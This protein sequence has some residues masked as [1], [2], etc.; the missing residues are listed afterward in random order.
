MAAERSRPPSR[1]RPSPTRR[2]TATPCAPTD[3]GDG[4]DPSS[5]GPSAR[6][7]PASAA[8]GGLERRP[9]RADHDR[10]AAARRAPTPSCPSS[11]STR[12][13]GDDGRASPPPCRAGRPRAPRRRRPAARR[14]RLQPRHG[15]HPRPPRRARHPRHRRGRR[16]YRRPRVGVLSTGDELVD[17][18]GPLA[19]RPDPRL[20]PRRRCCLVAAGRRRG[21][22]PRHS[23]P[24]TPRPSPRRSLRGRRRPATPCSRPAACRW[25]TSTSCKEVLDLIGDMRWM[26]VAIKPAKPFAFG[27]VDGVP[28]VRAAR[29][30]GVVDG[31]LR[32]VRPP[33][34]PAPGRPPR[35][36]PRPTLP[37]RPSPS[38]A[39]P[40]QP[41]GKLHF[42]RVVVRSPPTAGSRP[43]RP[44]ARARTSCRPW[45]RPTASP[46]VPDGAGVT[47]GGAGR[48]AAARGSCDHAAR[49]PQPLEDRFGRVHRDLRISV[50][51]RCNLRCT[52]CMP[53]EGM[54]W[55][56]RAELLTLRGDR[57]PR[58]ALRRALRLRLAS[59]SPAASPRCGPTCRCS[60][61]KLAAARRRPGADHQRRHPRRWSPTTSPP[62]A[63]G[64]S[65]SR[66]TRC[67]ASRVD[68][69][70]PAAT[71][72]HACSTASTPPSPPGSR[73]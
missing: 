54:E 11:R 5:C 35:R 44:A 57:A 43:A 67:G 52:Y 17:G 63:S 61:S 20:E 31:E 42:V 15:P 55:L 32:A 6:P 49:G 41:D 71:C 1:C 65:T 70:S 21:R 4:R 28:G 37:R 50:T 3:V 64:G 24:T 38:T 72:S 47:A 46:S 69:R 51:D 36:P 8:G 9:G 10:R 34:H 68:R 23:P 18:V 39:S 58:P 25:A 14:R 7:W 2:W 45:R 16:S 40:R 22:R 30:P 59:A 62:P 73:R 66:S 12:D 19:A 26:Q 60:S 27:L 48:R 53:E 29:Q 13:D 56:D 33:G